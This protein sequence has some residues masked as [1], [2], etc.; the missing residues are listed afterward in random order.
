MYPI[1]NFDNDLANPSNNSS[2][3]FHIHLISFPRL[4]FHQNNIFCLGCISP[5]NN[6]PAGNNHNFLGELFFYFWFPQNY[7]GGF[8]TRPYEK[9]QSLSHFP[10]SFYPLLNRRMGVEKVGKPAYA[11]VPV[12]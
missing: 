2:Q 8:E 11:A 9:D 6:I 5:Q 7:R 12:L 3:H 1:R 4:Q 10:Q